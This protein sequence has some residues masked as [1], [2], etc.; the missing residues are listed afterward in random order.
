MLHIRCY[1]PSVGYFMKTARILCIVLRPGRHV[2]SDLFR[3]QTEIWHEYFTATILQL[4]GERTNY[5]VKRISDLFDLVQHLP[6]MAELFNES[7]RIATEF[8]DIIIGTLN[9]DEE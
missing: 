7:N 8:E 3:I 2:A 6:R 9:Y 1:A 5:T 4:D